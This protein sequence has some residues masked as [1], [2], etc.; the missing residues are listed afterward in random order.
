[1]S[2]FLGFRRAEQS[3]AS[4]PNCVANEVQAIKSDKG[5]WQMAN[6]AWRSVVLGLLTP[7]SVR[8]AMKLEMKIYTLCGG[9]S[10]TK[11]EGRGAQDGG[12]SLPWLK[13]LRRQLPGTRTHTVDF[14]KLVPNTI[15][16]KGSTKQH[17]W[18]KCYFMITCKPDAKHDS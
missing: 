3:G 8:W 10:G 18:N 6:G 4:G 15:V 1:M 14:I 9:G 16:L 11:D 5:K 2:T 12:P 7:F 17:F 13:H